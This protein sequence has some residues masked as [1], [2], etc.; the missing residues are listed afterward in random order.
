MAYEV[1]VFTSADVSHPVGGTV[2]QPVSMLLFDGSTD[3]YAH[4]FD[5]NKSFDGG[6]VS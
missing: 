4:K 2:A 1:V 3:G 5:L 6:S